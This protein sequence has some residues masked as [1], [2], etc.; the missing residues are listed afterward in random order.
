MHTI[1][2]CPRC[3]K[4]FMYHQTDVHL[5]RITLIDEVGTNEIVDTVVCQECDEIERVAK[6]IRETA[7]EHDWL[8]AVIDSLGKHGI[9]L[10]IDAMRFLFEMES[11]L[12]K[13][14]PSTPME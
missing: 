9:P 10:T 6:G 3:G 13:T 8:G 7:S 5:V 12:L 14:N 4:D 2:K 1:T 11:D